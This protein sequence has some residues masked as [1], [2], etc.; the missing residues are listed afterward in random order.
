MGPSVPSSFLLLL[1]AASLLGGCG[2][3][4]DT[5]LVASP[6]RIDFG[7]MLHGDV[8]ERTL[9]LVNRSDED[10]TIRHTSF[11]CSCFALHPFRKLLHPGEERSLTVRFLSGDVPAGPLQG[12][13]LELVSSDRQHPRLRVSVVGEVVQ[14]LTILPTF[15]KLGLLGAPPSLEGRVVQVRP[16]PGMTV[17]LVRHRV[18]PSEAFE[19]QAT[20][21][22]GG[23]DV[24]VRWREPAVRGRGRFLGSLEIYSRVTGAGFEA[25]ELEHV[26][27]IHGEW[28]PR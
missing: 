14:S 13:Q 18:Q 1:L 28:P 5:G 8:S 27:R 6:E 7:R 19:S 20:E 22:D 24:S 17:E 15:V 10:V 3:G 9:T 23:F 4:D 2:G 16:G 25:R 12:K 26:V 11:N 21:V